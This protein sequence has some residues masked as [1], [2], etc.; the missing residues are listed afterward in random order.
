MPSPFLK[1]GG[2]INEWRKKNG[3]LY[4]LLLKV[5]SMKTLIFIEH[6]GKSKLQVIT[7]I[8]EFEYFILSTGT[9]YMAGNHSPRKRRVPNLWQ[10]LS[11]DLIIDYEWRRELQNRGMR[12]GPGRAS[13]NPLPSFRT[14]FI[15][16]Q[17][18]RLDVLLPGL[19]HRK[20]HMAMCFFLSPFCWVWMRG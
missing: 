16:A 11:K 17:G 18:M 13:R 10:A 19:V 5:M 4:E 3:H 8:I 14:S 15:L 6:S 1:E 12:Q 9:W 2:G 20:I 7:E